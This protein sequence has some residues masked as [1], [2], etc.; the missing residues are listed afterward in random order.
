MNFTRTRAGTLC[1]M[2][3][4][5]IPVPVR[6]RS[7]FSTDP[8]QIT[9]IMSLIIK[10][11]G[12]TEFESAPEGTGLAV[13]V[14]ITSPKTRETKFGPK[15]EFKFVFELDPASFGTRSNGTP[16]CIWSRGFTLSL[17]ERSNLTK[18]L[19]RWLGRAFTPSE[20]RNGFDVESMLGV[21]AKIIVSHE[22]YNGSVYSTILDLKPSNE[23]LNASG[24]FVREI[25][26]EARKNASEE[27]VPAA[28]NA[29]DWQTVK[30]H[31]GRNAGKELADLDESEFN[32]LYDN[33]LPK[34]KALPNPSAQDSALI[35]GLEAGKIAWT[36]PQSSLDEEIDY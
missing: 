23:P 32:K 19:T 29:G 3:V 25:D 30:V 31:V 22:E 24:T 20:M 36:N 21:S 9:K 4:V 15:Q 10:T 6:V 5:R 34:A 8:Q 26:R 1:P 11:S 28:A 13:C 33:W 14:D 12:Y 27:A 7:N 18:F 16:F 35:A 17:S 2:S